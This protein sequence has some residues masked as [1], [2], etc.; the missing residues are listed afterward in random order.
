MGSP[1]R[2]STVGKTLDVGAGVRVGV[3]VDVDVDVDVG[4][5]QSHCDGGRAADFGN[6][7]IHTWS[8]LPFVLS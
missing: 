4:A 2:P 5:S 3:G 8:P 7:P 6:L 1:S